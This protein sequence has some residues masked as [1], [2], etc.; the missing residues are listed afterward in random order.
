MESLIDFGAIDPN[1]AELLHKLVQARYNI[2]ISGGT[3]SGKTTFLNA[4]SMYIPNGE[5]VITV[6][7]SASSI[8]AN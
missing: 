3:G 8:I 2:V 6:E 7:D 1:V 4:L 5:R